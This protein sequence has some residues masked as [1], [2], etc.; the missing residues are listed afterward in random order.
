MVVIEHLQHLAPPLLGTAT[1]PYRP[2]KDF[3]PQWMDQETGSEK[4]FALG[5]RHTRESPGPC[6][7]DPTP[8]PLCCLCELPVP[9]AALWQP[10]GAF[11][12][13]GHIS[14]G[15]GFSRSAEPRLL[16]P[17][18][19]AELPWWAVIVKAR[20]KADKEGDGKGVGG[21]GRNSTSC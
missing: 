3:E 2:C 10:F 16:L 7:S 21:G 20:H 12:L 14:V 9:V 6:C 17:G 13:S 15:R 11:I 8:L 18:P 1:W 4:V 5:C 19:G